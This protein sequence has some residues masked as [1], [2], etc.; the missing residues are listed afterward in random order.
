[1]LNSSETVDSSCTVHTLATAQIVGLLESHL[2]QTTSNRAEPQLEQVFRSILMVANEYVP[3]LSGS[4]CLAYEAPDSPKDLMYIASFGPNSELIPGT[5]LATSQGITGRVFRSG[6]SCVRNDVKKDRSFFVGIDEKT[7]YQT[8]SLLCVPI[9]LEETVVGVLSL[10]NRQDPRGF[11][12]RDL[13]LMEIFCRYLSTSIQNLVDFHQQRQLALRDHLSGLHND[14]SFYIQLLREIEGCDRYGGDLS[15]VFLDL[16][17]FKAVVDTHGHLVGSQVLAE[18]GT[19]L[20]LTVSRP[21][22]T[23]ARY[24]GDEYVVI[25][26]GCDESEAVEIGEQIRLQIA[27][28]TYLTK[29]KREGIPALNLKNKFTASIG[30]ACYRKLN[31]DS[32]HPESRRTQLIRFADE[33][34]YRAKSLGKNQVITATQ[35]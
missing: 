13:K 29:P 4:I 3:S 1:M 34:M 11:R 6:R 30:I 33:A 27:E 32:E 18:V 26:P 9:C 25:L 8:Q 21:G 16:D 7:R 31:F 2:S 20:K 17:H 15:L 24:G 28:T 10:L 12:K 19:L 14:R 23:L 35:E 22:A 5:R